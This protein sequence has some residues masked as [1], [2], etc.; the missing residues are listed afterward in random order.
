MK[1]FKERYS[2]YDIEEKLEWE[3]SGNN[4]IRIIG[5]INLDQEDYGFLMEKLK[6]LRPYTGDIEVLMKYRL[7]QITSWI[8][9]M[10]YHEPSK[11]YITDYDAAVKNVPQHVVGHY[12]QMYSDAFCEYGFGTA[13]IDDLSVKGL[14]QIIALQ[15]GMSREEYGIL[16]DIIN[17]KNNLTIPKLYSENVFGQISY[18]MGQ[19]FR[20]LDEDTYCRVL[21]EVCRVYVDTR[22]NQYDKRDILL[23]NEMA[24]YT[25][26]DV[27]KEKCDRLG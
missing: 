23:K 11:I 21:E 19:M 18:R 27:F 5:D 12:L 13:S 6:A 2:L 10:R 3:F 25:L 1:V 16:F 17:S 4:K 8:F 14:F 26:V 15:A 22:I 7:A 24:A 9:Y 20:Y